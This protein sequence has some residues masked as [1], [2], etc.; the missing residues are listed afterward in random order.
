MRIILAVSEDGFI[1]DTG[2]EVPW[3]LPYDL[4]WF[5]M[6]T[7]NS[8]IGMGRKTWEMMPKPLVHRHH[9]TLSSKPLVSDFD[10]DVEQVYNIGNFKKRMIEE[11]GWV[12]GGAVVAEQF[13]EKDNIL[14][15]TEVYTTVCRGIKITLPDMKC[16]WK[17]RMMEENGYKFKLSINKIL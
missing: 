2:G 16:L 5:K 10:D 12:V 7:I 3:I 13:F 4:K 15:L 17:S 11:N 6:N 9:I 8:T 14:V 1:A